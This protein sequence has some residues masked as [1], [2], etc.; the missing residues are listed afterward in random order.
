MTTRSTIHVP[1]RTGRGLNDRVHHMQRHKITRM[2]QDVTRWAIRVDCGSYVPAPPCEVLLTRVAPSKGL[3][4]DN[5]QGSLK[6]IR[7]A[8][9]AWIGIDDGSE[10]VHYTYAQERG[11][12]GVRI[13]CT[14]PK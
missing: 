12:W 14:C 6:A 11:P 13:E 8:V 4:G 9:A 5:L 10:R 1:V 7:D 3:D 2:Q